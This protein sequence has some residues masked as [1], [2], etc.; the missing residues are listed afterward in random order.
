MLVEMLEDLGKVNN[1][2]GTIASLKHEIETLQQKH[3]SEMMDIRK[4]VCTILKDI[5]GSIVEEREKLIDE[6]RSACE[7]EALRRIEEAKSKQW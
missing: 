6:T 1:P 4:N 2:E 5:Q 7:V 3:A